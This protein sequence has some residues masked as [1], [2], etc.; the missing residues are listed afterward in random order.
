MPPLLFGEWRP[1]V[2]SL[3]SG[4]ATEA[5]NVFP[6]VVSY[7]PMP[8]LLAFATN[9]L[10]NGGNDSFTKVLLHCNGTN[11]STTFTDSNAGGSAHTWTA[12]GNA[13][14]STAT[15]KFGGASGL[16]DGTG[17]YV[18]TPDHADY[19]LGSGD[20]TLDGWFNVAG[21]AGATRFM[22]GTDDAADTSTNRTIDIKLDTANKIQAQAWVASTPTAVQ[23]TTAF[24]AAGWHHVAFTR[25]GNILRLFVDGVQEGGDV[26]ISGSIN[27]STA[28]TSL[29]KLGAFAGV[30]WNGS[31]DEWRLSVGIARWTTTFA[32][33]GVAYFLGG[34]CVGL[35]AARKADATWRV[36]GGTP[37][38]L[39]EY[40]PGGGGWVDISRTTGGVYSV[41]LTGDLWSFATFGTKVVAVN[42]NDA[43][44]V[45]DAEAAVGT[46]FAALGGTPPQARTVKQVGDFLILAGLATNSRKIRWSAINDITGWTV[47]L[48][49]CDEQEFPD[50][51]PVMGVAGNEIGYVVQDRSIRLMQFLPADTN[52]IFSFSRVLQERGCV[53]PYGFTT[54]GN[55]LYFI[56]EDGF[57]A[58]LGQQVFTI[59]QDKINE[60]FAVNSDI[61]R[62]GLLQCVS[63]MKPYVFWAYYKTPGSQNYDG[64]V[65]FDWS[66]QK[67]ARGSIEAQTWATLATSGLDL[68]TT[69]PE[70]GDALADSTALSLDSAAYVGG[71]PLVCAVN[72][73]GYLAG[74]NGPYLSPT[75]ETSEVHPVPGQR[76]FV[77]EVYPLC[78]APDCTITISTRESLQEMPVWGNSIPLDDGIGTASVYSDGRL[79]KVRYSAPAGVTWTHAQG[80][81]I[82]A[83]QSGSVA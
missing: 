43:P 56:A 53:S 65:V 12:N 35:Y 34:K 33:P 73:A 78:D 5:E 14:I 59:G 16:F 72:P 60:W 62:R 63:S 21:G 38:G 75:L 27:D 80:L 8:S 71:R 2:A 79:Q 67:W 50:G 26:A 28:T 40:N 29:G 83:Q 76:A 1:D 68:D 61:S 31:L 57:Y 24:A 30:E 15:S 69:G 4:I 66:L 64:I 10:A 18:S 77:S 44:Q 7:K 55:T 19:T 70:T 32:P 81:R 51:G 49:L 39:F 37:T 25:N 54:V 45:V 3:D 13:Q 46:A 22:W 20:W 23:G 48:N 42:I 6:G 17:D 82:D 9:T 52:L 58:L 36:Y 41:P 47:G 74:L 11:G